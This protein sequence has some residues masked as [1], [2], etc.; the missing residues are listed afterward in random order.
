MTQ[1]PSVGVWNICV[2]V[3]TCMCTYTYIYTHKFNMCSIYKKYIY[4]IFILKHIHL[5]RVSVKFIYQ[6]FCLLIHIY[7]LIPSSSL[8]LTFHYLEDTHETI[9]KMF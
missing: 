9:S 1:S 2:L 6:F 7:Y 8:S 5:N 4:W 3:Y